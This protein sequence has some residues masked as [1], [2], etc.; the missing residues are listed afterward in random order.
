MIVLSEN[1]IGLIGHEGGDVQGLLLIR[2]L[3]KTIMIGFHLL[4]RLRDETGRPCLGW[5]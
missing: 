1:E 2:Q 3:H 5:A 4:A